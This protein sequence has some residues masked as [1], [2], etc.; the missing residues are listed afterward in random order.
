M[1]RLATKLHYRHS[2][3]STSKYKNASFLLLSRCIISNGS[4]SGSVWEIEND[5]KKYI[6]KSHSIWIGD[7]SLWN[8]HANFITSLTHNT[9]RITFR[10]VLAA[11]HLDFNTLSRGIT[12]YIPLSQ[13]ENKS[14]CGHYCFV[15]VFVTYM[16]EAKPDSEEEIFRYFLFWLFY[17]RELIDRLNKGTR[18]VWFLW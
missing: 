10:N 1:Q 6:L 17:L 13:V 8:N 9:P 7:S 3:W 11:I 16:N 12:S 5:L 2:T 15:F 4:G 14:I 18:N